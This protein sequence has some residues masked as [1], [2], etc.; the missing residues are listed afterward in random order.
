[1]CKRIFAFMILFAFVAPTGVAF[2]APRISARIPAVSEASLDA[3]PAWR[4][5]PL[6]QRERILVR[7]A[8]LQALIAPDG[9]KPAEIRDILVEN[10]LVQNAMRREPLAL[11]LARINHVL[12]ALKSQENALAIMLDTDKPEEVKEYEER[13]GR[14]REAHHAWKA[15]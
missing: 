4:N 2:V 9:N 14:R 12:E 8:G 5:Q 1:M 10:A 13:L 3:G 11:A 7:Q 6:D 15:A